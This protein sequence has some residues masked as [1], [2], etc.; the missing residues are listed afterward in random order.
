MLRVPHRIGLNDFA[1]EGTF[2]WSDE[3]PLGYSNWGPKQPNGD[4]N[5]NGGL[6]CGDGAILYRFPDSHLLWADAPETNPSPYI[7][8]RKSTPAAATGGEMLGCAGGRWVLGAPYKQPA[9]TMRRLPPTIVR[10]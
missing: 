1:E 6:W 4:G 7:C 9:S 3:E 10:A 2:V 5:C 8:A